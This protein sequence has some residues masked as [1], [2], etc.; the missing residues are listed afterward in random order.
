M[1]HTYFLAVFRYFICASWISSNHSFTLFL[2]Q[3][4]GKETSCWNQK[5]CK[6]WQWGFISYISVSRTNIVLNHAVWFSWFPSIWQ[7]ATKILARQLI[8]LRQKISTLQ[9]SRAQIRGIAT[10]TQVNIFL[11]FLSSTHGG[12]LIFLF[13][14]H[15][16]LRRCRP[17]LQCLLACKVQVKQWELWTR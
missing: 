14:C 13:C 12:E 4:T 10:H 7:A 3:L 11:V 9:G 8:R 5:D 15:T 1:T 2:F 6:N 16:V 17:T